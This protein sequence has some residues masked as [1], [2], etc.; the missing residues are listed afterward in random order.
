MQLIDPFRQVQS[1]G[2]LL[3]LMQR[4]GDFLHLIVA[5]IILL[6]RH[7]F[8]KGVDGDVFLQGRA[9]LINQGHH[10]R[11]EVMFDCKHNST[12]GDPDDLTSS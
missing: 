3:Q 5:W 8:L 6:Q 7:T 2:Q 10:R 9:A 11:V 4:Q 12:I 1:G